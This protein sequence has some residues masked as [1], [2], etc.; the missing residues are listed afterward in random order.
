[1][2]EELGKI[3]KLDIEQF[4][5]RKLYVVPLIFSGADA[6]PDYKEKLEKYWREVNEQIANQEAKVGKIKRVYHESMAVGG[7]EGLKIIMEIN[8]FSHLIAKDKFENG[9]IFEATEQ[10]EL[11]DEILL[12]LKQNVPARVGSGSLHICRIVFKNF[13]PLFVN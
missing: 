9:A 6:P 2:A 10:A 5:L 1:M 8:S 3:E 7:A 12:L 11:A 13:L 4:G